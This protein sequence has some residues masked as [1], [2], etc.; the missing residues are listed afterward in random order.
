MAFQ[1]TPNTQLMRQT[2]SDVIPRL[3]GWFKLL[4]LLLLL[5]LNKQCSLLQY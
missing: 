2:H 5:L 3:N 1:H 4:L